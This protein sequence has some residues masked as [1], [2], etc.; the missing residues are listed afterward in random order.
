MGQRATGRMAR[1]LRFG[2][3]YLGVFH[4]MILYFGS[5]V[6]LSL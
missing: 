2:V 6:V 1:F 3:T 5:R 4:D